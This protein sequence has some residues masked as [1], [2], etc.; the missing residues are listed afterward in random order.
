MVGFFVFDNTTICQTKQNTFLIIHRLPGM[1][2][3]PFP[4]FPSSL[5]LVTA[6]PYFVPFNHYPCRFVSG[7]LNA[8]YGI[9]SPR[10]SL[11]PPSLSV[12][13]YRTF[14]SHRSID[15]LW[16]S[17]PLWPVP[18]S[19]RRSLPVFSFASICQF[20][21]LSAVP[22]SRERRGVSRRRKFRLRKDDGLPVRPG[23]PLNLLRNYPGPVRSQKWLLN[24]GEGWRVVWS[25][26]GDASFVSPWFERID[27]ASFFSR[28]L[29]DYCFWRWLTIGFRREI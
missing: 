9:T 15:R 26:K 18:S 5:Q 21:P 1:K 16:N 2:F 3:W 25:N 20:F 13:I 14:F 4:P 17:S 24:R 28:E 8:R 6:V 23:S 10:C 12:T 19:L 7:P 29:R 27:Q 22:S 11:A